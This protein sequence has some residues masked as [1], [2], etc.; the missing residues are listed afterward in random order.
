VPLYVWVA[1]GSA[2]GGVVR[3]LLGALIQQKTGTTFP[4]STL[5]I[6]VTGSLALGFL[7]RY[8]LGTAAV[9]PEVRALLTSGFC[10]GYTTFSTFSYEAV[11]LLEEG[12]YH[13]AA[14]YIGLSVVF[15]LAGTFI[16]IGLAREA[17]ALRGRL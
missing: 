7:L 15:S 14:W 2:A 10:G 17:L 5:L 8:S 3:F 16:G 6:N 13:R 1:A 9:R 4:L 11:A 12:D